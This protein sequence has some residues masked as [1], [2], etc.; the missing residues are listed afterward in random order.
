MDPN[1]MDVSPAESAAGTASGV[2]QQ[3]R[4]QESETSAMADDNAQQQRAGESNASTAN[5]NVTEGNGET[6]EDGNDVDL[7][8]LEKR[9]IDFTQINN[10]EMMYVHSSQWMLYA[11][12]LARAEKVCEFHQIMPHVNHG[13]R[14]EERT[15]DI[16][17]T[18]LGNPAKLSD[19]RRVSYNFD[20]MCL[21]LFNLVSGKTPHM[22]M[23]P[24]MMASAMAFPSCLANG[25]HCHDSAER[26]DSLH[27]QLH[28]QSDRI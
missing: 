22:T 11:G 2:T 18:M 15:A 12:L 1:P 20:L 26:D 14:Q 8:K 4:P 5:E 13:V 28:R 9:N 19:N 10:E 23:Q 6:E 27:S 25:I 16:I 7:P 17:N 21:R 3:P 24:T